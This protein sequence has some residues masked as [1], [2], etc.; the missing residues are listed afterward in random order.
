MMPTDVVE[1]VTNALIDRFVPVGLDRI[2]LKEAGTELTV[3]DNINSLVGYGG[4]F[5]G[6]TRFKVW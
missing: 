2:V 5:L 3:S 1:Y 4:M 6:V